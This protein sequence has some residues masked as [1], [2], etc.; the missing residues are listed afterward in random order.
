MLAPKQFVPGA[1]NG[2]PNAIS[3]GNC[4]G[5]TVLAYATG[6]SVVILSS[7]LQVLQIVEGTADDSVVCLK[8][9]PQGGKLAA[10]VGT[11]V[12]LYEPDLE[13]SDSR[14]VYWKQ[15]Q[16]IDTE[17]SVK[18]LSWGGQDLLLAAGS[19]LSLWQ[20]KP[21]VTHTSED[22]GSAQEKTDAGTS[23]EKRKQTDQTITPTDKKENTVSYPCCIW[24][25]Q[26]V[27]DVHYSAYSP[28]GTYFATAGEYDRLLKIWYRHTSVLPQDKGEPQGTAAPQLR[29]IYLPH[30]RS[31]T[32]M[33]WRKEAIS[34]PRP[35]ILL[36]QSRDWIARL[37]LETGTSTTPRFSI[38]SVIECAKN[39]P[40]S[41]LY[42]ET[43]VS[44]QTQP[45]KS[46]KQQTMEKETT[47]RKK[48]KED[49]KLKSDS[50][51]SSAKTENDSLNENEFNERHSKLPFEY[52]HENDYICGVPAQ[53]SSAKDEGSLV[54][55][56][57]KGNPQQRRQ[58]PSVSMWVQLANVNMYGPGPKLRFIKRKSIKAQQGTNIKEELEKLKEEKDNMEGG[59]S[60]QEEQR[61]PNA[62]HQ[63]FQ[64]VDKARAHLL[65]QSSSQQTSSRSTYSSSVTSSFA[66]L[67][68]SFLPAAMFPVCLSFSDSTNNERNISALFGGGGGGGGGA[69]GQLRLPSSLFYPSKLNIYLYRMH[70]AITCKCVDIQGPANTRIDYGPSSRCFGH[71]SP[72]QRIIVH[73]NAV[74]FPYVFSLDAAKGGI[75]WQAAETAVADPPFVLRDVSVMQKID[76]VRWAHTAPIFFAATADGIFVYLVEQKLKKKP[77]K[78]KGRT[79]AKKKRLL[80][81]EE[82]FRL[83][84]PIGILNN[85]E[86]ISPTLKDLHVLSADIGI[87]KETNEKEEDEE[88]I[89][90]GG[91]RYRKKKME[92]LLL[93]GVASHKIYVW[94]L[95]I[96]ALHQVRE[97]LA[98]MMESDVVVVEAS[99]SEVGAENSKV[100]DMRQRNKFLFRVQPNLFSK[101]KNVPASI[102]TDASITASSDLATH[103]SNV[104]LGAGGR[105]IQN[106]DIVVDTKYFFVHEFRKNEEDDGEH[107]CC[108]AA[109]DGPST[110]STHDMRTSG[111]GEKNKED[112]EEELKQRSKRLTTFTEVLPYSFL[113]GSSTGNVRAWKL[114]KN[115]ETNKNEEGDKEQPL[116]LLCVAEFKAHAPQAVDS[117]SIAPSNNRFCTTAGN[118]VRIWELESSAW[119]QVELEATS[120]LLLPQQMDDPSS[121]TPIRAAWLALG[122]GKALLA[123]GKED[124]VKVYNAESSHYNKSYCLPCWKEIALLQLSSFDVQWNFSASSSLSPS[125]SST[126]SSSYTEDG[127]AKRGIARSLGSS[128]SALLTR[129]N[130][131]NNNRK[132]ITCTSLCWKPDGTLFVATSNS[133]LLVFT[134]WLKQSISAALPSSSLPSSASSSAS[135]S[136]TNT[137]RSSRY[138]AIFSA[139]RSNTD[140]TKKNNICFTT[141]SRNRNIFN[142]DELLSNLLQTASHRH[143]S[144]PLYH[145]VVLME[146][147]ME[148]NF[149][150][151]GKILNHLYHSLSSAFAM[152]N[153]NCDTQQYKVVER[154]S[155]PDLSI[156]FEHSA[157]STFSSASSSASTTSTSTEEAT[158][159]TTT[160]AASALFAPA[161]TSTY[162][163]ASS[164]FASSST[165]SSASSLFSSS[166][167][168][169]RGWGSSATSTTASSS[170]PTNNASSDSDSDSDD[171]ADDNDM[172]EEEKQALEERKKEIEAKESALGEFTSEK[173]EKLAE[174]L[175]TA[176]IPEVSGPLQMQLLAII[177]TFKQMKD[178]QGALDHCGVRFTLA[179]KIFNFMKRSLPLPLR[180]TSLASKEWAWALH[181]EA[182]ETLVES[183]VPKQPSW[184][185]IKGLGL[186]YWL[187]NPT[188]VLSV[189]ENMAR[190]QFSEKKDPCDCALFYLAMGKKSHLVG[191]FKAVKNEKLFN[192]FSNNFEGPE[193]ERWRTV[194]LKNAYHLL[195]KQSFWLAAA[196]FLVAGKSNLSKVLNICL[197]NLQDTQL[198]L[199]VC[200]LVE[201]E[202]RDDV[203]PAMYKQVLEEHVIPM[204]QAQGDIWLESMGLWLLR[205][206][207]DALKVLVDAKGDDSDDKQQKGQ[208]GRSSLRSSASSSPSAVSYANR[209]SPVAAGLS[210]SSS[211]TS[212]PSSSR[213]Q[214]LSITQKLPSHLDFPQTTIDAQASS[215]KTSFSASVLYYYRFLKTNKMLR[216]FTTKSEWDEALQRK[217]VYTY[218]HNGSSLHAL[219][220]LLEESKRWRKSGSIIAAANVP[221]NEKKQT[222]TTSS[223][224]M[225]WKY[226]WSDSE[227]ESDS[228]S[229]S[230]NGSGKSEKDKKR[231]EAD[232]NAVNLQLKKEVCLQAI[233]QYLTT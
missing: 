66:K 155:I 230:E 92:D 150:L 5:T 206:Y 114:M 44:C 19:Q 231:I 186:G 58:A 6:G 154:V 143:S 30:P 212:S 199:W 40:V 125:S 159:Q 188:T 126:S 215:S 112:G 187:K 64:W 116:K 69:A 17:H 108:S 12:V 196:F 107:F 79:R 190:A 205:R 169:S 77:A 51:A 33:S 3:W 218:L 10:G 29:F 95:R 120:S 145:P 197:K 90:S 195:S 124:E 136:L 57:V 216:N 72:V 52:T 97:T 142:S 200:R 207:Q 26:C 162:S 182:Q 37:W 42:Y 93:V 217:S 119:P 48:Q 211:T 87:N 100:R 214:Q 99:S 84:L 83:V 70:G 210:A 146:Y 41:W 194:A 20:L 202:P 59:S 74:D 2:L 123:L 203:L 168:F 127:N 98:A 213:S 156:I 91:T 76:L 165:T 173:A 102:A 117:I 78:G 185:M 46:N 43:N 141:G 174:L 49:C 55:W 53:H 115:D 54:I 209:S 180:P 222:T 192:F 110:S 109:L 223:S 122:D 23:S 198:A 13:R 24:R 73:P 36:T 86:G 148:A 137:P 177:D 75:L 88:E 9:S 47:D 171:D 167:L 96:N 131:N 138:D 193:N 140:L 149:T 89:E 104:L 227:S 31:V 14:A 8:W 25:Q 1:A 175:T 151:V 28:D 22:H 232:A 18:S 105:P 152:N 189:T 153:S 103:H 121:S 81:E 16:L 179:V 35:N 71:H 221:T 204:A 229:D 208:G 60:T 39:T 82:S 111:I 94:S 27:K 56:R 139:G 67:S 135:S 65:L 147:L 113:T 233:V 176:S 21:P 38:C 226:G 161:S 133:Q 101:K 7:S 228:D 201:G 183:V 224:A 166:S 45:T 160:S 85:S 219:A 106:G 178:G 225:S 220:L 130:N 172:S 129:K 61:N 11:C 4:R 157:S 62:P 132:L 191:L 163:S 170:Q 15:A 118:Q 134:K 80:T 50:E 63:D 184:D 68:S 144:L 158:S 32:S 34:Q 164:L 181:S 128:G